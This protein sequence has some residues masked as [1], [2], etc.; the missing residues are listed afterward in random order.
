MV[1][2]DFDIMGIRPGPHE[3]D[4]P[5]II[6]PDAVL[7]LAP[8][9]QAFQAIARRD[10][11]IVQVLCSMQHAQFPAGDRLNLPRQPLRG[12]AFPDFPGLAV[13]ESDDHAPSITC[14]VI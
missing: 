8:P 6:D 10:A 4:T 5:L 1:V 3:T 9:F 2:Y 11:Q 12:L 13:L 7:A 14:L